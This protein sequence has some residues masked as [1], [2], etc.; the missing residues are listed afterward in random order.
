MGIIVFACVY[1]VFSALFMEETLSSS[2]CVLLIF[3]NDSWLGMLASGLS[4]AFHW[5]MFQFLCHMFAYS[6][7][8][9][10]KCDASYFV[11]LLKIALAV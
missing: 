8:E 9:I 11:F 7:F 1:P 10:K 4:I 2:L 5:S 6:S 3:A